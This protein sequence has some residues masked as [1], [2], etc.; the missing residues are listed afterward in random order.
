MRRTRIARF[1]CECLDQWIAARMAVPE[2]GVGIR[3][4][5]G[6]EEEEGCWQFC[7]GIGAVVFSGLADAIRRHG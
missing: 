6:M 1:N 2:R 5:V 3:F 7:H 4:A